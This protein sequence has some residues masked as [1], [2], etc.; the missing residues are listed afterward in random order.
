M[1]GKGRKH[2]EQIFQFI[3]MGGIVGNWK[4]TLRYWGDNDDHF[5]HGYLTV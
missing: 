1:T 5:S 4:V 3:T 2:V